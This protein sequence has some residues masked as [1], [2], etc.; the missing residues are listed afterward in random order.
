VKF[1]KEIMMTIKKYIIEN[2]DDHPHDISKV[3]MNY[4]GIARPTATSYLN[5]LIA[6]GKIEKTG[7]GRYP[8]Y[9]LKKHCIK[10][11]RSLSAPLD[12]DVL[13]R[14]EILEHVRMLPENVRAICQYGFTEMVNN[15]IDHSA[16]SILTITL[17]LDS[18]H[19][20]MYI[21]DDGVGIFDKIQKDLGL[22]NPKHSIL[23]LV[24]GKFTSDPENH[25]GEGIFFS[26][27]MFDTFII[28]SRTLRFIGNSG[29]KDWL[30][31]EKDNYEGTVVY[32]EIAINSNRL[33]MDVFNEF[34]DPDKIPGF[35]RTVIPVKLM[36]YEGELL[37][38]RS[39]AKRL[40]LR[41]D[42][43]LEVILDFE[44]VVIIGQGFADQIFRV[45]SQAHPDVHIEVINTSSDIDKMIAHVTSSV[46]R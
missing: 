26:S 11:K 13:W 29:S 12:E 35:H 10:V 1:T 21:E 23:E 4:F 15:A 16:G 34:S 9:Q 46:K 42:H 2:I 19:I 39:Q 18:K 32:M 33:I 37:L 17:I 24:K 7:G 25:S 30:I 20:Q 43:F 8:G 31:E 22:D 41:F 36:E 14:E 45:F 44:G 28:F 27:R 5:D 3:L 38:S 6:D 40:I